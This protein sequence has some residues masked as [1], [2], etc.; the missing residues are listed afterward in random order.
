[1]LP[2]TRRAA[3]LESPV[4][5]PRHR[6]PANANFVQYDPHPNPSDYDRGAALWWISRAEL[7]EER[8]A[9]HARL[10]DSG[11]LRDLAVAPPTAAVTHRGHLIGT[12]GV[13]IGVALMLLMIYA[14][15]RY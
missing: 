11:E 7:R 14:V 5:D 4:R 15:L 8:A 1:M 9:E 3:P 12:A 2:I 13:A 6:T 10:A